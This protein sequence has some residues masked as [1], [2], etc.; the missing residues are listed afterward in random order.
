MLRKSVAGLELPD[1]RLGT[2][3]DKDMTSVR[4][5]SATSD[6]VPVLRAVYQY[7]RR[8]D[9][10]DNGLKIRGIGE[11]GSARARA[12]RVVLTIA[13]GSRRRS[14]QLSGGSASWLRWH[15]H[16]ASAGIPLLDETLT[17]TRCRN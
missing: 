1:A 16:V 9:K 8:A 12:E 5:R 14:N 7:E 11:A 10:S 15:A 2:V 13:Q 17:A 4:S 3:C 6:G